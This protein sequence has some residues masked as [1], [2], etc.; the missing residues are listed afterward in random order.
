M[1]PGFFAVLFL[2]FP[3]SLAADP[4]QDLLKQDFS[5]SQSLLIQ[6]AVF[7][8]IGR[9]ANE[10]EVL[11]IAKNLIPWAVLEG[12]SPET[13]ADLILKMD[14]ARKFGFSFEESEDAI[15]VSAKREISE[16]DFPL[17][18]L[19]LKETNQA[20]ISEE[21][22]NRFLDVALERNWSGFSVLAAGRALAAGKLVDFPQNRLATR[23]LN[24]FSPK[25]SR[26]PW[27]RWESDFKSVLD[28]K[29]EG[30]SY[31]LL[32]NLKKL[33]SQIEKGDAG[34]LA[35]ARSVENSLNEVGQIVIGDRP[36]FEPVSEPPLVPNLPEPNEPVPSHSEAKEDW[37]VLSAST[38]KKVAGEWVG[39]PYKWGSSAKTGT[40][41]SGFTYR[42]L[43][44]G[45]IGV[46]EKLVSRASSAQSKLGVPVGHD[47]M[48][49]GD[50]I[51][52]SASP[53]QSKV[54]HVGL[55]LSPKEFAHASSTRGVIFDHVDSKWWLERFVLS[56]R[57]FSKVVE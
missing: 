26:E 18:V 3:I 42:A 14:T 4:F 45:R 54:T 29:L 38:L 52:F 15:P 6:N 24:R 40:D 2:S 21:V 39:T 30:T 23:I 32:S 7:Q 37:H 19:Y 53:N 48:R 44:D 9:R 17:I 57:L 47:E 51:F 5:K 50:L 56:R 27:S 22:R 28:G 55:V 33:H 25:G 34:S 1:K 36:K 43:T 20:R 16:K 35:K 31:I 12:L 10:K 8:R 46:P 11:Q 49:A 41:C 13:V